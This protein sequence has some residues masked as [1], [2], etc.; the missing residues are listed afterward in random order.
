MKYLTIIL[1]FLP[2]FL[3]AQVEDT[4][5]TITYEVEVVDGKVTVVETDANNIVLTKADPT[6]KTIAEIKA[7]LRAQRDELNEAITQVTAER[8]HKLERIQFL[9]ERRAAQ[10]EQLNNLRERRNKIKTA[11]NSL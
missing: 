9:Q 6:V 7:E 4:T 1:F 5:A 11:L 2:L 8:Q 10:L 3:S